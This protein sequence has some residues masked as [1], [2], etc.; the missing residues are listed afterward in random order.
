[1]LEGA[2]VPAK[3]VMAYM[4]VGYDKNETWERIWHRFHGMTASGIQPFPMVYDCRDKDPPQYRRLKEFQRWVLTGL[5][6]AVPFSKYKPT[7]RRSKQSPR[8]P[9]C[10]REISA[11]S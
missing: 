7:S 5:Y 1:M 3:H 6:R 9:P 4:L 2:G 10:L 11:N 8:K